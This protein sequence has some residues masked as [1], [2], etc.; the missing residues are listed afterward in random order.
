MALTRAEFRAAVPQ[1]L[2]ARVVAV[3]DGRFH[4]VCEG[5]GCVAD[6]RGAIAS[7]SLQ[8]AADFLRRLAVAEFAVD[9]RLLSSPRYGPPTS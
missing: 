3:R 5:R 8:H 1:G 6:D 2:G 7:P 4:V 9:L